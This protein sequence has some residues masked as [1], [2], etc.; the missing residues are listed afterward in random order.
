M[1]LICFSQKMCSPIIQQFIN[2]LLHK[3]QKSFPIELK[4]F[5][6]TLHFYSP[7]AYEYVRK[8]FINVLPHQS[9]IRKWLS[10]VNNEPG[11]SIVALEHVSELC[12]KAEAADKKLY[13]SLTCDEMA[14]KKYVEFDGKQWHGFVDVGNNSNDCEDNTEATN[15]FVFML[16]GINMYFKIVIAYYFI[17]TLTGKEKSHILSDILHVDIIIEFQFVI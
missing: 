4:Q 14:I 15:V 11:I 3:K 6:C 16:V 5:A 10:S 17:H 7:A 1:F 2:K 13:F 12:Q 9:T 8:T